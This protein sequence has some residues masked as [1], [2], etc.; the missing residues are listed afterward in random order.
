[1][2]A[3]EGY[4]ESDI[5]ELGKIKNFPKPKRQTPEDLECMPLAHHCSIENDIP[6]VQNF[7]WIIHLNGKGLHMICSNCGTVL[8]LEEVLNAYEED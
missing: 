4:V 2:R 8:T 7:K 1:M 5:S 6:V 3:K